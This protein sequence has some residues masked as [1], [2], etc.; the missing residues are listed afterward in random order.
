MGDDRAGEAASEGPCGAVALRVVAAAA[1]HVVR[2]RRFADFPRVLTFLENVA[3]AAPEL[4]P[5]QHLAKLRLG[6][7]AKI[8][9]NML[10]ED[11]PQGKIYDAIDTYFP[12]NEAPLHHSKATAKD[13]EMVQTAQENF[14]ILILRLLSDSMQKDIYVQKY[15]ETDYGEAFVNVVEKLFCDYLCQLE[16]VLPEP[17][18]QMLLEAASVQTPSQLPQPSATI[19]NQY[20]SAVG[21]QRAGYDE[22]PPSPPPPSS[23]PRQSGDE[24]PQTPPRSPQP[25]RS[26]SVDSPSC[27]SEGDSHRQSSETTEDLVPD[28]ESEGSTSPFQCRR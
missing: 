18:F 8:V 3:E 27:I 17:Q 26:R 25:D 24:D 1:W 2:G 22:P 12:E 5:F 7:Q 20:F 11:Q 13:L 9:M 4:V 10:Q 19:L 14:R 16:H 6:L 23:A 15:L 28:S 21:Y